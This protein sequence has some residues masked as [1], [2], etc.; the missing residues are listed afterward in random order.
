MAE[1]QQPT[2]EVRSPP[3]TAEGRADP[4]N[5]LPGLRYTNTPVHTLSFRLFSVSLV[6]LGDNSKKKEKKTRLRLNAQL[7][8]VFVKIN[9]HRS[10][11]TKPPLI[12]KIEYRL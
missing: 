7:L 2:A 4:A 3:Q 9:N 10:I 6:L 12:S 8:F 5:R 1:V 11:K